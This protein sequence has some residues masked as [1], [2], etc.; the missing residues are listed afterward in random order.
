MRM[1]GLRLILA[2]FLLA[3]ALP[4]LAVQPDEMLKDPAL[5]ARAR[6]LSEIVRCPVCQG[7]NIDDSN[8]GIARDLRLLIR[9]RLTKGDSDDEVIA[10]LTDRYGDFILFRPRVSGPN[11]IL[12]GAGPAL[13]L[14]ALLGAFLYIRRRSSAGPPAVEAPLT[15]EEQERLEALTSAPPM[16]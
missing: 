5:E 14:V 13:L 15:R 12:W 9:E 8:A 10:Y 4:A 11:L 6:A 2:V 3:F 16:E 1:R 7:E